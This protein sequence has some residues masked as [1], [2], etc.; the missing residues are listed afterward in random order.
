VSVRLNVDLGELAGESEALYACAHIAN[1]ACGGHAGDDASMKRAIELCRAHGTRLGA[2]PSYPDREGFGRRPLDMSPAALFASVAAQ[3]AR[4]AVL[5]R[6]A[7]QPIA[8]MKPHGALYH[9]ADRDSALAEALV[10]ASLQ[11]LGERITVVG[12]SS[13]ALA[14]AAARAGLGFAREAFA[15][16]GE[17]LDGSLVPRS[18]PGA[19]I[20]DPASAA[21]RA[22]QLAL[23]LNVETV[24]IHGD[25]PRSAALAAAVRNALDAH[26]AGGLT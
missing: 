8:Y 17:R 22:R 25:T 20:V 3:C 1:V 7:R 14:S 24:C 21:A 6:K 4:L 13:G 19:L 9:A 26:A 11:S 10:A 23:S 18:E 16:R 5:A 15:D 2:H 12:P